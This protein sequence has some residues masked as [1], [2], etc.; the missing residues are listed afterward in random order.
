MSPPKFIH[1]TATT[2]MQE[3]NFLDKMEKFSSGTLNKDSWDRKRTRSLSPEEMGSCKLGALMQSIQ[4]D[5]DD[6][7]IINK[8]HNPRRLIW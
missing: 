8:D 6:I 2:S 3:S 1:S 5:I 4:H 7:G